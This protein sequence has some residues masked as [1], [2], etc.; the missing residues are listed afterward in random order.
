MLVVGALNQI[1]IIRDAASAA[2]LFDRR[3][4][5]LKKGNPFGIG[6]LMVAMTMGAYVSFDF[7][8]TDA[9]GRIR[10]VLRGA[11]LGAQT[12]W[13]RTDQGALAQS[14]AG[15]RG[16]IGPW[17]MGCGRRRLGKPPRCPAGRHLSPAAFSPLR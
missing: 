11:Q 17:P 9:T 8:E 15:T 16:A 6:A 7:I 5:I 13:A 2:T 1:M 3:Q 10:S 12:G 4:A 14:R